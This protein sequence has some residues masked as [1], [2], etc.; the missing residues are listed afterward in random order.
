MSTISKNAYFR[1]FFLVLAN[2]WPIERAKICAK[3]KTN[4][5]MEA[6]FFKDFY[7]PN[8][9]AVQLIQHIL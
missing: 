6:D 9:I 8:F 1:Q 4:K 2:F 5:W 3:P 7:K